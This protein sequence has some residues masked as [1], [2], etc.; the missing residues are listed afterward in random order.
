VNAKP[1][2]VVEFEEHLLADGFRV[3]HHPAVDLRGITGKAPLRRT[4][5]RLLADEMQRELARD[6]MDGM[7]LGHIF[8]R[9]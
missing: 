6:A 1:K 5:R 7:T 8:G 3:G 2:T 9:A 4:D